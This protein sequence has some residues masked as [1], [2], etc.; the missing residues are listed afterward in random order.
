MIQSVKQLI[1]WT[2]QYKKRLYIGY[3]F[4]IFH[5]MATAMPI[6]GVSYILHLL[7]RDAQGIEK[8]SEDWIWKSLL[9]IIAC[10]FARFLFSYLRAISQESIAYERTAEERIEIGDILKRVSLGFFSKK[11]IGEISTAVT[12]DLSYFEMYAMKFLDILINGYIMA[13]VMIICLCFYNVY[14]AGVAMLG[15]ICSAIALKGLE[16]ASKRNLAVHQL[17]QDEMASAVIEYVRG[18]ALAK[19][20][21]FSGS[22]K[23]RVEKAYDA[24]SAI[25]I[26][27]ELDFVGYNA[28]HLLCLKLAALMIVVLS[29]YFTIQGDM[30][31]SVM[32]MMVIFSFIIFSNVE[33]M[34]NAFHVMKILDEAMK[35]IETVKSADFID[36]DGK[37]IELD[38]HHIQ[39]DHVTFSYED[40]PVVK[41]V[42][43]SVPQKSTTAIVGHSGSGKTTITKLIARFYDVDSGEVKVGDC[44]V[45]KMNVD[46]LLSNISMVF[47]NV[48]LF[49]DTIEN[50]IRFGKPDAT[51]D[52]I[53]QVA[54]EACCHDF[55]MNLPQGYQTIIGD[56]GGT[57]SGGE[58][59]RVSIARAILKDAPIIILDEATASIDPENEEAI[60]EAINHL[61]KDKTIIII[62][63]RLATIQKADQILVMD[64]GRI[65]QQGTHESLIEEEGIYQNFWK[66]R[67]QAENWE[68]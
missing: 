21:R 51:M 60:Q 12:T 38:Q 31:I 68:I 5:A 33:A 30:E 48:Y 65:A 54:K 35:K 41:D 64:Q 19:S 66:I 24:H 36:E 26:K 18:I 16:R 55:I 23:Q 37:D 61:I 52:E 46:S 28:L 4:S 42:S 56:G 43:F 14:I 44:D 53:H 58:K 32:L 20:F 59:Q 40:T 11:S 9:F 22:A 39:F 62:A 13:F 50:N 10:V 57:L 63:H 34:N 6:M 67:S 7:I 45:K 25:N 49:K 27:L 15:V 17:T 8:M 2:K 3:I 1:A 47:Q 29:A